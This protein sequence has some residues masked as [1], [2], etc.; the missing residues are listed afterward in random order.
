[1]E[2]YCTKPSAQ[3]WTSLIFFSCFA[4]LGGLILLTLFIGVVTTSMDQAQSEAL[5]A[6]DV[7]KRFLALGPKH[8]L[9]KDDIVIYK[10]VFTTLDLDGGGTIDED[11]LKIGLTS[12]GVKVTDEQLREMLLEV[13]EDGSGEIDMAE[14]AEFMIK[15]DKDKGSSKSVMTLRKSAPRSTASAGASTSGLKGAFG[16][17]ARKLFGMHSEKAAVLPHSQSLVEEEEEEEEGEEGEDEVEGSA[18]EEPEQKVPEDEE[19]GARAAP[20]STK[21]R[22][23]GASFM[24]SSVGDFD[25]SHNRYVWATVIAAMSPRSVASPP[26]AA[27]MLIHLHLRPAHPQRESQQGHGQSHRFHGRRCDENQQGRTTDTVGGGSTVHTW[28]RDFDAVCCAVLPVSSA[29]TVSGRG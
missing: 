3:P 9:Q 20:T 16:V 24:V 29:N 14:F 10:T 26:T 7:E 17:S 6:L 15:L 8:G 28:E 23:G 21:A 12:I 13:D 4:I 2:E 11:E 22:Q 1:M 27:S 18:M 19:V 25:G 5:E